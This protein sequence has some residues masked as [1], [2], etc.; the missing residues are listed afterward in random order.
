MMTFDGVFEPEWMACSRIENG[1]WL[2]T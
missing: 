1:E 2:S